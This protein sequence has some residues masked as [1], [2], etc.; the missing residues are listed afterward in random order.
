MG[1]G[2]EKRK[3]PRKSAKQAGA[4]EAAGAAIKDRLFDRRLKGFNRLFQGGQVFEFSTLESV[5]DIDFA[6][7]LFVLV[8]RIVVA[9]DQ[10]SRIVDAVEQGYREGGEV[11]LA[12]ALREPSAL[13]GQS[14]PREGEKPRELRF[15]NRFECRKCGK[16]YQE[17]EPRLFSF[18]NPFGACP[19][20]QGFGN[21]IDFDLS[22]VIPDSS[23][24][25]AEGAIEPWTKPKYRGLQADLRKFAKSHDIPMDVPWRELDPEQQQHVVSGGE[26]FPGI[27]GFFAWL[28]RKKYK[29]HVRVFLSRYRGYARCPDS[30]AGPLP[31]D[32]PQLNIDGKNTPKAH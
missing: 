18:N 7:P 19:R 31:S 24:T 9:A 8:D 32:P 3:R 20:C 25:L 6:Q 4:E 21:T 1:G 15:S 11:I 14:A 22:L 12:P 13:S 26:K 16:A 17:P 23:K 10:R 5:L 28:E 30:G 27:Q 29:L 2:A